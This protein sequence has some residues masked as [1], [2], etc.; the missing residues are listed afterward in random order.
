MQEA[1]KPTIM[2]AAMDMLPS[3]AEG[4][5]MR[6]GTWLKL[7]E[8]VRRASG[9]QHPPSPP[10]FLPQPLPLSDTTDTTEN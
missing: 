5:D 1:S 3:P 6:E 9:V 8:D 4:A 2:P 7:E 10:R